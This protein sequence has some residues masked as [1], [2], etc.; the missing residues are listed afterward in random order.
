MVD[1]MLGQE[2]NAK[3]DV[4][5]ITRPQEQKEQENEEQDFS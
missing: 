5:L 2:D 1:R 3:K 4:F